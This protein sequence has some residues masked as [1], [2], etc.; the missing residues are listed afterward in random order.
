MN[1][2]V[3]IITP[4]YNGEAYISRFLESVLSQRHRPIELIII[5]DGSTD[6]TEHVLCSFKERLE[7]E[8]INFIY[9]QQENKGQSAAINL[10]LPIFT[11]DYVAFVDSDD[12]LPPEAIEKKVD[13]M[14]QHPQI[15]LLIN[16]VKVLDFETLSVLGTMERKKPSGKDHLFADLILGNNV[17]Y[18]PGGYFWRTT[19]FRDAMPK[20]LQIVSPREIGQNFQL[21]MPI[22]YKYPIGY[23]DDYLYFY[24]VRKG[25][26]S[27]TKHTYE[28]AIKN[29]DVART[30]LIHIADNAEHEPTKR[31]HIQDLID[32]RYY[33][34]LMNISYNYR[35]KS[36]YKDYK[37]KWIKMQVGDD[38]VK[39][40]MFKWRHSIHMTLLRIRTFF[41]HFCSTK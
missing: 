37:D 4:C 18:T 23:I 26:H 1:K 34:E 30:V 15:G 5:N 8:G 10:A 27:R 19:M 16:K 41:A 7:Q 22:A 13:Y 33:R 20:P 21:I 29:W 25:S 32:S 11:G 14:E 17:F 39:N 3:S 40:T 6:N 35:I 36:Q 9:L 2:N 31:K 12:I 38:F 24:L 28:Q